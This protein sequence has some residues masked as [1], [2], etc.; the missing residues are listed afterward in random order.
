M[1]YNIDFMNIKNQ[2]EF[3]CALIEGNLKIAEENFKKGAD[4]RARNTKLWSAVH[5]A[6]IGSNLEVVKFVLNQDSEINVKDINGQNPLHVAAAYGREATV[7]YFL[8]KTQLYVDDVDNY[9]K[10]S[11]HITAQNGHKNT[12]EILLKNKANVCAQDLSG[13]SPLHYAIINNHTNIAKFF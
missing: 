12:V 3:F 6:A 7:E 8:E 9:R 1:K 11:L 4:I 13:R 2:D 10:T 5:F